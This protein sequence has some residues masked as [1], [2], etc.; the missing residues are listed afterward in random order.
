MSVIKKIASI[1]LSITNDLDGLQVHENAFISE[2]M[3]F[4]RQKRLVISLPSAES[5]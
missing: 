4:I 3:I 1:S 5:R 2:T